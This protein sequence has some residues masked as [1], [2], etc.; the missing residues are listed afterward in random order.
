MVLHVCKVSP[1][2]NTYPHI[3]SAKFRCDAIRVVLGCS[4]LAFVISKSIDK[5]DYWID[6]RAELRDFTSQ[7][8]KRSR[9]PDRRFL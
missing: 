9:V 1:G 3:G 7:D 4:G 6:I 2:E 5:V 8:I